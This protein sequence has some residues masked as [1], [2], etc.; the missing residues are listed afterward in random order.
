MT[1]TT[2]VREF[3][4]LGSSEVRELRLAQ[5]ALFL[6]V[7]LAALTGNLLVV[8][9]TLLDRR[10]RAPMYFFL[11]HLSVLDLCLVSV[12]VPQSVHNSLVNG[13]AISLRG[14]VAQVFSVISIAASE[15]SILTAMSHDRYAAVCRPLR[16]GAIVDRGAC[17]KMAAA[18]WLGGGLFGAMYTAGTVTLSFCGSNLIQQFL[19][20]VPSSLKISCS[21]THVVIAVSEATA[22]SLAFVAFVFIVVSYARI[23]GA[24]LRMPAAEGRAGAFSTCLPRLAGV[25][26]FVANAAFVYLKPLSDPPSA[27]DLLVSVFYAAVPPALNPVIYSLRNRDMKTT[28]RRMI[29]GKCL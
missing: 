27:Q 10:L 8:A 19:C 3:L 26:L 5:A 12:T 24:V 2:K 18:S 20:D 28:L 14:C 22:F 4:L 21:E 17:G 6:P 13:R 1:N 16:Y 25:T 29:A 7:Y 23:F 9:V 15:L 11:G